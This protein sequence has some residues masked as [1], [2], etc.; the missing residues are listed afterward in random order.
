M[1]TQHAGTDIRTSMRAEAK[2]TGHV[3][4]AAG[5]M[6]VSTSTPTV[7]ST[8]RTLPRGTAA[9]T[10]RD[11]ELDLL[12][13]MLDN[14][15]SGTNV[16]AISAIDG[17][18][19][20]G[21]T[22][23]AIH[24]GNKL[25]EH[26]PDGQL[27]VNLHG[28][29]PGVSPTQPADVL[30]TLLSAIGV[31]AQQIPVELDAKAAMW[32]DRISNKRVLIVLDDARGYDQVEALL[33]GSGASLVLV[34]SRSRLADLTSMHAAEPISLDI[35]AQDQA[36]Q[37]FSRIAARPMTVDGSRYIADIVK[38]CGYLPLAICLVAA[39]L[40]HHPSWTVN[41]LLNELK[42]AQSR[43]SQLSGATVSVQSA[44]HLSYQELPRTRQRF[45]RRLSL[46]PGLD[47]DSHAAAA[48]NGVTMNAARS[49]L[50]ALYDDH[51]IDETARDR[52]RMH[53]LVHE[54]G[55]LL[56]SK[57]APEGENAAINR[58]LDY[59]EATAAVAVSLI[60]PHS[61]SVPSWQ[62]ESAFVARSDI[63]DYDKAL[64]WLDV[65][66]NNLLNC[67][68]YAASNAHD[69]RLVQMIRLL[70]NFFIQFGLWRQS[71]SMVSAACDA[72]N[73]LHD[74]SG[75][76]FCLGSLGQ[77]K[78]L[79]GDLSG[80]AETLSSARDIYQS[81]ADA[82]GEARVLLNIGK[83]D[84]LLG[85]YDDAMKVLER[86]LSL[87]GSSSDL[88]G[89]ADVLSNLG[90]V[91]REKAQY[92]AAAEMLGRALH[93][94]KEIS[95]RRGEADALTDMASVRRFMGYYAEAKV[96]LDSALI[97][98]REINE[99]LGEAVALTSLSAVLRETGDFQGALRAGESSL[100][101]NR[102][103]GSRYG[104]AD[105]LVQMAA[106][107]RRVGD[108]RGALAAAEETLST[109]RA[110]N[111]RLGEA[112]ALTEV[113]AALR[114]A[115]EHQD[116]SAR[117]RE[118]VAIYRDVGNQHGEAEAL[119]HLGNTLLE[120][121][122]VADAEVCFLRALEAAES[123]E[124]AIEM[125]RA[126]AG[127]YQCGSKSGDTINAESNRQEAIGIYEKMGVVEGK[128]LVFP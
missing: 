31:D 124:C 71:M 75:Y 88:A 115:G 27:F 74:E 72:A 35:L 55:R 112:E 107:L 46:T 5:N 17:M 73:R 95:N 82:V 33:P 26:Y 98:Y 10:G 45:F 81:R 2:D 96:C 101:I 58:L 49:Q 85:A 116:S 111:S 102:T 20:I 87:F 117:L 94:Y 51:L 8:V 32:R 61:P 60:A 99:R 9:F 23:F 106:T 78:Y 118:A 14:R 127:L 65:E 63:D 92:H 110:L 38:F 18:A 93:T 48:L 25:A 104:E 24:A 105:A 53:D 69:R 67:V 77:L 100:Q 19:G 39:R 37:L 119:N 28:H 34:T 89:E 84:W 11:A 68:Q 90:A 40:A 109:C 42:A 44:F 86:A 22:A 4:Q 36:V 122:E 70:T 113:G 123:V 91:L 103:I 1:N 114:A 126:H 80:A 47:F 62:N 41:D 13:Q 52:Y 59:Y 12:L 29:T 30:V 57:D 54:F 66:Q 7:S 120:L 64:S 6:Y 21:K 125:A 83:L 76:A 43:L 3:Y 56:V 128:S 79:M 16:I 15:S 108:S 121:G 50:S 97:I